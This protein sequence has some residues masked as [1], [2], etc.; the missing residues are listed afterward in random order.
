MSECIL[1]WIYY[2]IGH[3]EEVRVKIAVISRPKVTRSPFVGLSL[4][5]SLSVYHAMPRISARTWIESLSPS[6]KAGLPITHS[7][8]G[9]THS[10]II[11]RTALCVQRYNNHDV[12]TTARLQLRQR[13]R[14][15]AATHASRSSIFGT[16]H[17][18]T[19]FKFQAPVAFSSPCTI[20]FHPCSLASWAFYICIGRH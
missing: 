10:V 9:H 1:E 3:E 17:V 6:S 5:L 18:H 7:S 8:K 12:A 16:P 13:G 19:L 20:P 11:P 2:L 4:T 15:H 14:Q